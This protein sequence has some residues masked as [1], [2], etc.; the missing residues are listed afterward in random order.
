LLSFA[1]LL[2]AQANGN[3]VSIKTQSDVTLIATIPFEFGAGNA[4]LP[5]G[6]YTIK[7]PLQNLIAV[8]HTNRKS[9]ASAHIID[10]RSES[11]KV[12]TETKLIFRRYGDQYF[13][14][15]CWMEGFN[16]GSEVV[17]SRR[18]RSLERELE[19]ELTSGKAM[20]TPAAELVS[21]VARCQ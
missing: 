21:V 13:L 19:Q 17:K 15:H 6:E 2:F 20:K 16:V 1:G 18:E 10:I 9:G 5:A 12:Q 8:K 7:F 3:G 4:W 14:A 11:A